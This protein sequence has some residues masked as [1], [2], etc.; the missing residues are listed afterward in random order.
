MIYIIFLLDLIIFLIKIMILTQ[1][2]ITLI[3]QYL[4]INKK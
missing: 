1:K 4:S 2:N 3:N